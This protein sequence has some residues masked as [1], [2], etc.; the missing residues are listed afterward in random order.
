MDYY[1]YTVILIPFLSYTQLIQRVNLTVKSSRV[2][3]ISC[4][5]S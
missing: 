3:V 2:N 5:F 4:F 1:L